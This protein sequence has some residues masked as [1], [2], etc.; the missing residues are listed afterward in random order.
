MPGPILSWRIAEE[1][2]DTFTPDRLSRH[3]SPAPDFEMLCSGP[4]RK[5]AEHLQAAWLLARDLQARGIALRRPIGLGV[6]RR[7]GRLHEA[8]LAVEIIPGTV[9]LDECISRCGPR[10]DSL[11]LPEGRDLTDLFM[12]FTARLQKACVLPPD[13]HLGDVLLRPAADGSPELLVANAT[14]LAPKPSATGRM[15][16]DSHRLLNAAL[17]G[18][19]PPQPLLLYTRSYLQRLVGWCRSAVQKSVDL[20]RELR[21]IPTRQPHG[22]PS[23]RFRCGGLRGCVLGGPHAEV[24]LG[25]LQKPEDLFARPDAVVLKN[26][27]TTTAILV[28]GPAGPLHVK[29]Y[30]PKGRLFGLKYLLRRSRARRAWCFARRL[31]GGQAPTPDV[32]GYAEQRRFG[33]LQAAYLVTPGL[34]GAER[35]DDYIE[36]RFSDGSMREK[37]SLIHRMAGMV[38][39]VHGRGLVHGDLK[40][41]NILAAPDRAGETFWLIDLDAA[42]LRSPAHFEAC[43]RDL[44]RLNCSFLDTR[45]LSRTH[46]LRFLKAYLQDR[47]AGIRQAWR[48]IQDLSA[49]RLR[50]SGRRFSS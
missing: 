9:P 21:F 28:P 15:R 12:I 45:R 4:S 36:R 44:A 22:R 49:R 18:N 25:I 8:R 40:A 32:L 47:P 7:F 33:F 38:R 13:F 42:R 2:T 30:N 27:P 19:A 26:S 50:A 41:S 29:R 1:F 48:V 14:R 6:A 34:A 10:P 20:V 46:R 5:R 31:D 39:A 11:R 17:W 23:C 3:E 37:I 24:I 43:C 35:L 16:P